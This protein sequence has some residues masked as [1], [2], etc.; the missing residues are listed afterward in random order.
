VL[1]PAET[2]AIVE[3]I[4]SLRE[5]APVPSAPPPAG[6]IVIPPP[7]AAPAPGSTVVPFDS[8]AAGGGSAP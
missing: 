6:P 2:S 3:Y 8:A 1:T 4:R 5:V 7:A